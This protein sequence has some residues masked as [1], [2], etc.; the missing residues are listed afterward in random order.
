L[1]LINFYNDLSEELEKI[2]KEQM[3]GG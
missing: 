2:H 3:K 1:E